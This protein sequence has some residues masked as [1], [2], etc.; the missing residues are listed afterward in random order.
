[1]KLH[2][3]AGK[4]ALWI[5]WRSLSLNHYLQLEGWVPLTKV[6]QWWARRVA[7]PDQVNGEQPWNVIE[8][9]VFVCFYPWSRSRFNKYVKLRLFVAGIYLLT[10]PICQKDLWKMPSKLKKWI[11]TWTTNTISVSVVS[12]HLCCEC[13]CIYDEYV[14][15]YVMY[16]YIYWCVVIFTFKLGRRTNFQNETAQ[17]ILGKQYIYERHWQNSEKP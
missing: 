9:G 3:Q 13:A 7:G 6:G 1:M 8:H 16:A 11:P 5:K 17:A 14:I 12:A 2:L 10:E 15:V 4:N